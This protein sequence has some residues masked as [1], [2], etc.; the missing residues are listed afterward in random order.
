MLKNSALSFHGLTARYGEVIAY[1]NLEQIELASGICPKA[2]R[3]VD[4]E[5]RL[6]NA[7]HVQDT[8]QSSLA[9]VA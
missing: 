5:V 7:L 2:T 8:L 9:E 3:G 4:P 1:H 6:F